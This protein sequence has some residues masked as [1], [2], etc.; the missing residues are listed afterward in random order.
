[1]TTTTKNMTEECEAILIASR[2]Y[3]IENS[4]WP[5]DVITINYLLTQSAA[6]KTVYDELSALS[7]QQRAQFLDQLVGTLSFWSPENAIEMRAARDR[8]ID[9]NKKISTLA[10]DL[11]DLLEERSAIEN[12]HPFNSNTH[13]HI[14]NVIKE[15]SRDNYHFRSFLAEPLQALAGQFDLKY[16]PYLPAV[17]K[18]IG[19]DADA[20]EIYATDPRTEAATSS[21]RS[22]KAD[23]VRAV[24]SM[25]DELKDTPGLNFSQDFSVSDSAMADIVNTCL[26]LSA[27]ELVDGA[28]VKNLRHREKRSL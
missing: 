23:F 6:M 26:K 8:L 24:L 25:I 1:M 7:A 4:I 27:E 5:T 28:H 14:V 16:W 3:N 18:E 21:N 12:Q 11:A 17:I 20:A 15:A 22:S 19:D 2:N 9:V 10:K 13:Y